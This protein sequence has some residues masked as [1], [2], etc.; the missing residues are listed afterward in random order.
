LT[1]V[2]NALHITGELTQATEAGQ[3]IAALMAEGYPIDMG[4]LSGVQSM[5]FWAMSC[6]VIPGSGWVHISFSDR[7]RKQALVIDHTGT[8]IYTA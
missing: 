1:R 5:P 6:L 8:R 7:P 4:N 3:Q 2:G